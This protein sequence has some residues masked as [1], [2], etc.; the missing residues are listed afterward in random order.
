MGNLLGFKGTMNK[1]AAFQWDEY[2]YEW[3]SDRRYVDFVPGDQVIDCT[4]PRMWNDDGWLYNTTQTTCRDSEFDLYGDSAN[5]GSLPVWENQLAKFG[6]VQDRLREW[7]SDV[8]DKIK[9]LSCMQIAMLD[10]DGFRMDKALQITVDAL[11][12]F[13]DYERT[14]AK[15]YGKDNFY[16]YGEVIGTSQQAAIYIGRGKQPDMYVDNVTVAALATNETDAGGYIRN[17]GLSALDGSSFQYIIY[18]PMTRFLGYV[19]RVPHPSIFCLVVADCC[20]T[21]STA[22]LAR[23][24]STLSDT[25]RT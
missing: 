7:R 6:S 5:T 2:D 1:T 20:S 22:R 8:L 23:V 12:D 9:H 3:M 21:D 25:G 11:A 15:Q 24:A 17:Y 14:C 13:A 16:I 10:I 4:Y 18:G 19:H